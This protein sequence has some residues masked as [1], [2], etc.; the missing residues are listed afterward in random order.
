MSSSDFLLRLIKLCSCIE[1][2]SVLRVTCLPSCQLISLFRYIYVMTFWLSSVT[3]C[4]FQVFFVD[5]GN[6]AEMSR[7]ELRELP[8]HLLIT[9]F[10]VRV[11][12]LLPKKVWKS[13]YSNT[14]IFLNTDKL[15]SISSW[16]IKLSIHVVISS[17]FAQNL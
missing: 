9:P 5:Y 14:I 7:E 17:W 3:I 16:L 1:I 4:L 13:L 8:T 12:I 6:S 2:G 10:Q 11:L 15:L